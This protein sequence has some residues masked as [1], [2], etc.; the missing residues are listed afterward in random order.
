MVRKVSIKEFEDRVDPETKVSTIRKAASEPVEIK[1]LSGI[2]AE[3]IKANEQRQADEKT[4]FEQEQSMLQELNQN[5]KAGK[6]DVSSLEP[7]LREIANRPEPVRPSYE[8]TVQR[9]MHG[10]ISTMTARPVYED[11]K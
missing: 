6:T 7:L 4:R 2:L 1:G 11:S 8:F 5:I 10:L 9:D 3:L